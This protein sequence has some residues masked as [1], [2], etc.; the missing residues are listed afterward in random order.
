MQDQQN[1]PSLDPRFLKLLAVVVLLTLASGTLYGR[2]T[3]RWGPSADLVASAG[4]VRQFPKT[5]GA[6]QMAQDNTMPDNVQHML[7]CAGYINRI[8]FH[9]ETGQSIGIAII[10][11]P[12]GPTA[13]H[14]PE[15]CY[16]SR[17][18]TM[19]EKPQ[20][21]FFEE[22]G[23]SF[24]GIRFQS[25]HVGTEQLQ[26]YYAWSNGQEWKASD[27]PRIEFGGNQLLYK[28]QVSGNVAREFS[29]ELEDPALAFIHALSETSWSP[30]ITQSTP[31]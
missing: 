29:K 9:Q 10:V 8:Y 1:S 4:H 25:R 12:P 6:W 14:T 23:H 26:V 2:L 17:S 19:K 21:L 24:W 3:Q 30:V 7:E 31:N 13:V 11:G 16:S 18:H 5:L 27:H 15:I 28:I 22:P 20:K